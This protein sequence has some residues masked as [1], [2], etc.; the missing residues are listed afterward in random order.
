[1]T[2]ASAAAR[3]AWIGCLAASGCIAP[4]TTA[5]AARG[6][7]GAERAEESVRHLAAG[8]CVPEPRE[9]QRCVDGE[10]YCLVS[11]GRPGGSSAALWCRQGRWTMEHEGNLP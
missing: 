11:W 2:R 8:R 10:D 3:L 1:M 4:R 6:M 7:A 5:A 9:D